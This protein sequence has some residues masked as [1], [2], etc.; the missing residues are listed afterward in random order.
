[1]K[2]K[3]FVVNLQ[4]GQGENRKYRNIF[5]EILEEEKKKNEE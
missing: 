2:R 4:Q 5:E 3:D 1:M